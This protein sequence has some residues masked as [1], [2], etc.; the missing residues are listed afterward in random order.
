MSHQ[1]YSV[2]SKITEEIESDFGKMKVGRG[3]QHTFVGINFNLSLKGKV[4]ISMK[5][6]I[7]ECIHDLKNITGMIK[8][9][10]T[11][12]KHNIFEVNDNAE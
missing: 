10:K 6:Y 9:S 1:D 8:H 2:I 7:K 12:G 4:I 5:N 11:P 3:N